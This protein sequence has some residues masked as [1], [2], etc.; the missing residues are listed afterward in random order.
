[1]GLT[2]SSKYG[3]RRGGYCCSDLNCILC[4]ERNRA[5]KMEKE[6]RIEERRTLHGWRWLKHFL[7]IS[8]WIE[9]RQSLGNRS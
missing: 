8:Q 5:E 1:M 4:G 3:R 2:R 7:G 9:R 6:R